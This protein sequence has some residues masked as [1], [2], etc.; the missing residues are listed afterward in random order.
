MAGMTSLIAERE[1]DP[2]FL[3]GSER[4]G[5]TLLRLM[6]AHHRAIECAPE[7]E[8]LVEAVPD[9][10]GWPELE[11]YYDWLATNRVFQP[12]HLTID[13]SLDY[14]ALARSFLAQHARRAKKPIHGVTCH[15]HFDRLLRIWPR[16]RFVHIVRD[17]RD[18]ARSCIGMGWAGNVW[19][20]AERWIVAEELWAGLAPRLG[21]GQA[22]ELRYE[23]LIRDPAGQLARLCAFL[24]ADYDPGMLEYSRDSSYERPDPNLIGQWRKKLSREELALLEAR[25]GTLLRQRGYEESGVPCARVGPWRRLVLAAEDRMG[26]FRFRRERYGLAHLVRSKL[27]RVLHLRGW[28]RALQRVE[29]EVDNRHLQ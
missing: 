12:H 14:P 8:F 23:D 4:S 1:A 20:G 17:G 25:I 7:F 16:A 21:Q 9:G 18:V 5:T 19:H 15:K 11:G 27:A 24:G 22:F 2:F 6:L 26:R 29:N 3:V 10:G 13:R 28:Q